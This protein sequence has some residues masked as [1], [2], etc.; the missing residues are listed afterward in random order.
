MD[1]V[2]FLYQTVCQYGGS[3]RNVD[4]IITSYY[5]SR[6]FKHFSPTRVE[7]WDA[8]EQRL[9]QS[10]DAP[11]EDSMF[12]FLVYEALRGLGVI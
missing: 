11:S 2:C 10:Y 12:Y 9:L 1:I 6:V 5:G 7:I 4:G 3:Y 8:R